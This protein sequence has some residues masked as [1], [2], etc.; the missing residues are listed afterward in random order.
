[1]RKHH[2]KRPV[3]RFAARLVTAAAA[4]SISLS[5]V[6]M[7][8]GGTPAYG[9]GVSS[10]DAADHFALDQLGKPYQ[11]G[12]AGLS[13]YD[14]SGLAYRA[15]RTVGVV[16]PRAAAQQYDAGTHVP[17]SQLR[18]GDLVFWAGNNSQ[19]STIYHVAIYAGYGRVVHAPRSG[20][21]VST[22]SLQAWGQVMPLA[23]RP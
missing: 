13:A 11:Y 23:T 12:A 21:R 1:M 5:A 16:L 4:T 10:G 14:C 20:T 22:M 15:W 17:L 2:S 8:V 19:P 18:P 7:A 3:V 9:A 6:L